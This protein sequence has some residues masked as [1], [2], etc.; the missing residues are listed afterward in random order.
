MG[1][2]VAGAVAIWGNA[3][4]GGVIG[5]GTLVSLVGVFMYGSSTRKTER[6]EKRVEK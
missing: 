6:E 2:L 1:L 4:A 5:V 3:I